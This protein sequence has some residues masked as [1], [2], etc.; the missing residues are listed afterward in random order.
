MSNF[1]HHTLIPERERFR[2]RSTLF[3]GLIVCATLISGLAIPNTSLQAQG[4][5]SARK[6]QYVLN[7]SK[8]VTWP[9][10]GDPQIDLCLLGNDPVHPD[11]ESLEGKTVGGRKIQFTQYKN[12]RLVSQCEILFIGASEKRITRQVLSELANAPVL[13]ISDQPEFIQD[14]GIIEL[15]RKGNRLAFD[16]GLEAANSAQLKISS[17]LLRLAGNKPGSNQ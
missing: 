11:L 1:R 16:I 14:G 5:E 15:Y 10:H 8:F 6:S 17:K 4:T 12:R 3:S 7:V 2:L 13:T 9:E